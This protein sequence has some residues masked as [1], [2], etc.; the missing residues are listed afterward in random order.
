[1][2]KVKKAQKAAQRETAGEFMAAKLESTD[3]EAADFK[4]KTRAEIHTMLKAALL[5]S[6]PMDDETELENPLKLEDVRQEAGMEK[7]ANDLRTCKEL[8]DDCKI[9]RDVYVKPTSRLATAEAKLMRLGEAEFK[10][11]GKSLE[12]LKPKKVDERKAARK[13]AKHIAKKAI[14]ACMDAETKP[15]KM[16]E[17]LEADVK[18]VGEMAHDDTTHTDTD[19][20][21]SLTIAPK[22]AAQTWGKR[23]E[24]SCE[25]NS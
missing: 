12:G 8:G 13:A 16:K 17:C 24:I 21:D 18:K 2:K 3:T 25:Q 23:L 22:V 9:S 5:D 1:M 10:A 4:P 6:A 19:I 7:V 11:S 20:A 14:S 15:E